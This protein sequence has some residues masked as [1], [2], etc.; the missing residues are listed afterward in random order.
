MEH[1]IVE[2]IAELELELVQGQE[3]EPEPAQGQELGLEVHNSFQDPVL[4]LHL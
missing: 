2:Q 1:A 4:R 3:Q